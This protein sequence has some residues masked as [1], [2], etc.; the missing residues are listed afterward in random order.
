MFQARISPWDCFSAQFHMKFRLLGP[1]DFHF[2]AQIPKKIT[3]GDWLQAASGYGRRL[4]TV[5]ILSYGR[6]MFMDASRKK[7][8]SL[9][10]L[11]KKAWTELSS[12][13][14]QSVDSCVHRFAFE[15]LPG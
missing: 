14:I 2:W 8:K 6:C 5:P 3:G 7:E 1:A 10:C 12:Q 13:G 15:V 4:V 9:R 11:K